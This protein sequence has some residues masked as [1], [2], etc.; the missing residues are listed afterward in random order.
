MEYSSPVSSGGG[1]KVSP[2]PKKY[3]GHILVADELFRSGIIT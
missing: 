1:V 2:P 3:H